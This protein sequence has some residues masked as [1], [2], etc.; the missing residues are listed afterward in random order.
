MT[1]LVILYI[2]H[3]IWWARLNS[4]LLVASFRLRLSCWICFLIQRMVI[5]IVL[6]LHMLSFALYSRVLVKNIYFS[7][8]W[9]ISSW[10]EVEFAEESLHLSIFAFSNG[11]K[12]YFFFNYCL[13]FPP[14]FSLLRFWVCLCYLHVKS[15]LSPCL[16][17][18]SVQQAF[19]EGGCLTCL[20]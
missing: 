5:M 6:F 15:P 1:S 19:L 14:F 10:C 13:D 12:M 17:E 9:G 4:T 2:G 20:L 16:I 8:G 18:K 11:R 7:M 3:F